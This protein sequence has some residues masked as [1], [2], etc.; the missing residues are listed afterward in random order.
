MKYARSI[1][2]VELD[3]SRVEDIT[4]E[5]LM[6]LNKIFNKGNLDEATKIQ[7]QNIL[8]QYEI[9]KDGTNKLKE[10]LLG[11]SFRGVLDVTKDLFFNNGENSADAW[12]KGFDNVMK[13]YLKNLFSREFLEDAVQNFYDE[14]D[15][16][17][18]DGL[19]ADEKI[20]LEKLWDEIEKRGNERLD[21]LQN[22]LGVD[23][24]DKTSGGS[25][26]SEG[27]TR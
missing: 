8:D 2:K 18:K 14:Y 26:G 20:Y 17:A 16:L 10:E 27:I 21:Q 15:Q 13:D 25:L 23:L 9:W 24:S 22:D 1:K 3:L 7:V 12:Q 6:D 11:I 19:T 5:N 4:K